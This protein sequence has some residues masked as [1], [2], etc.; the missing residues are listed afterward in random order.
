MS[1]QRPLR[2]PV[3]ASAIVSLPLRFGQLADERPRAPLVVYGEWRLS[4]RDV[5]AAANRLAHRL[6]ALGVGR[7]VAVGLCLDRGPDLLVAILAV[8]KAGGAYVPLD[9]HWPADRLRR[10]RAAAGPAVFVTRTAFLALVTADDR[11]DRATVVDL[12]RDQAAIAAGSSANPDVAIDPDQWCYLLFTSGST[13]TPKGVPVTHRNLAGLFPP[14]T[15]ALGFGPDD[16]WTWFHSASF[17]FSVWEIW[18]ALLHG[19]CLVIVPEHIRQDP[20]ALGELIADEQV[21]VFSQT[22]SAYRRVLHDERFHSCVAGSRLRY[23]ALSGEAVRRDD[24]AGWLARGHRARLINTYAITETAG[25]LTLRIYGAD[26]ATEAGARNLGL[27]LPGR[28]VLVLDAAGDPVPDGAAGELWVGGDCVTPGYLSA[29]E[30]AA[31]FSELA[32]PGAGVLRGYRTGDRVC[33]IADGSLEYLGRVDDQLKFRGH[34]IEPGDIETALRAHPGVRD[35]AVALR[36]DGTGNQ[37]LTAYIVGGG[38]NTG[39]VT[40]EARKAEAYKAD[41]WPSIGAYGIY[42]QWL[43]GLMNAEPVRLAAYRAAFVAAVPGKVVLDIGTGEDAVLARLCVDA[44]AAHVYAVEVLE[45]AAQR[46]R[47]L[48]R[49]LGLEERITVL[50]GDI[51]DVALPRPVDVCTQGI[52]GNIGGADGIAATWN[53]ARRHFAP[54]CVPVPEVCVTRIAALELPAGVRPGSDPGPCF[55]P[56]AADYARR[57]FASVGEPFDLRLCLRNVGDGDLL[58]DPA[59][60]EVLDFHGE[61]A[62]MHAGSAELTIAR[63]GLFDGCLLWTV[64]TAGAGGVVDYFREQKAWLPVFLPLADEPVPVRKGDRLYLQW[65]SRLESDPQFPDYFLEARLDGAGGSVDLRHVTRHRAGFAGG[66]RLHRQLLAQLEQPAPVDAEQVSVTELRHWLDARVPE[67][68]VPQSWVFLPELP[69][70]PGGKLDREAL[71]APGSARPRLAGPPVA[72]RTGPERELARLWTEVLGIDAPGVEDD[73]FELGGD[74]ISAVQLTTRIQRWLDAGVPLAALFE[75]PTIAGLA[76][77]LEERFADAVA[78]ALARPATGQS[79]TQP[80]MQLP[81]ASGARRVPLTFSQQSLWFLQSLYPGD[82]SASEQFAIRLRG[83]LDRVA[84]ERAWDQLIH[85]HPILSARFEPE[86]EI[87]VR[88]VIPDLVREGVT[89]ITSL[90]PIS[91]DLTGIAEAALR[92]PFDLA[93]GPLVRALLFRESA[94]SQVL[95]VTA[96]HIVAD[97]MSVPVLQADLA[98]LYA[99]EELPAAA[100]YADLAQQPA[101]QQGHDVAAGLE[102]WRHQLADP[103]PP[104]LQGLVRPPATARVSRRVAFTL[105]AGQADGLRRLARAANATPYMAMLAAF[106]TLLARL[107]GQADLCIGTPMTLR[108]TPELRDV[109]GCLVNP[110]VLRVP[111]EPARSFREQLDAERTGALA[112]FRHRAVPFSRVVQAVAP[113]R[114]LGVHP[115]FQILFSWEPAPTAVTAADGVEFEVISVPAARASYFN[116]E[117]ALRD[118]GEGAALSGYLAWSTT[119]LEDW[120]AE[121]LPGRLR[122]LLADVLARPDVPLE[123]LTL[124]APA[125]RRQIVQEWN[126]TAAPLPAEHGLH[127]VFLA[128]AA[129]SPDAVAIRAGSLAVSYGELASASAALAVE[130][131]RC[132]AQGRHVGIAIGRSPDLVLAVLAVLRAGGTVV[133]L[134]PGFP[135]SRLG[136]MA[137]DADLALLL[138]AGAPPDEARLPGLPVLDLATWPRPAAGSPPPAVSLP[139]VAGDA[140]AMM[141]Y[142]SGSTGQPKGARTTHRCAVNRCHW[143]WHAFGFSDGEVFALRTSLNF[144]DAWWEMFGA[145]GN[146]VP[147]QV[148]PDDVAT[149]P[150]RLPGFLAATGVTQLVLVPSLLRA[151]LEQLPATGR[152]LPALRWCITS[153][154]P[155]TPEL[156]AD[157]R[158]LLPGMTVLNTYGTSEIWDATAFDTRQL[159]AGAVRVPIGK[160]VANTRVYVVD[161]AGEVLPPGIPGELCVAGPGV[162]PGYWRR[163]ELTAEKF[164]T[165][166]LPELPAERVYRTGDRARFLP[167]GA[168]EC[169]GRLDAQFKLR[170]QRIEPAEIEQALARHPAVAA[171]VA[172]LVGD[173]GSTLLAA[174]VVRAPG[175]MPPGETPLA[176]VLRAHLEDCLPAW[177][178]PTAWCELAALPLTPTGKLDRLGGLAAASASPPVCHG[179]ADALLPR[180]DTQRELASLWCALLGRPAVGVEDNFFHLGGHSLLAARLLARIRSAFG[181]QLELRAL[182]AAPTVVALAAAIDARRQGAPPDGP[183]MLP[184]PPNASGS[185]PALSF[186]Q[187]R[188]WFLEQLDP[189]SPAYNVAWTIHCSGLLRLPALRAALDALV[190]RHPSLRTRFPAVAGRPVPIIDPPGPAPLEFRDLG[191]MDDPGAEL[192]RQLTS[193]AREPF[194]LGRGP[195][196]RATLLKTGERDHYLLL[197]A[198]HIVTDATSNHL[199]FAELAA[200]LSGEPEASPHPALPLT[201]SGFARRQRAEAGSPRQKSALDWWRERLAGAPAALEL[202]TDR[203]R[204]AEQRFA[205]AWVQR[206]VPLPLSAAL[207][208][209]AREQ[210]CTPYMVLLAAFKALLHRYSGAVDVLVGTPVEG[211]LTADVEPVVGLFINTLVMRTDLA[212]DPAFSTLLARVRETTLDAQAHQEVPFEQLVEA[213]APE[214]SLSRSPVFQVMFNLVRLPERRRRTGDLELRVDRLIDQ[215]VSSFDLTLTAAAD[216]QTLALTFEYATDLFDPET[217]SQL[218]DAYLC[219]LE[220]ALRDPEQR[221]S[222]LPLLDLRARQ[223]LLALGRNATAASRGEPVHRTVS[224]R[225]LCSPDAVAVQLGGDTLTYAGLEGRASRLSRHLLG[226]GLGHRARIGICLPRTPDYLVAVLAVLKSGAAYVPLDPTYPPE[227]LAAMATDAS[228]SGVVVNAVTRDLLAVAAVCVDLDADGAAIACQPAADPATAVEPEDTA[229]VLYTSGST[230][231]P[232]GVVVTHA[233]LAGA[234]AAWRSAYDL[235]PGESHLQMASAAF[236]VFTGDWVRSLGTG[237]RLVLCPRDVLLDPPAL[238]ALLRTGRIRVAEFVPAI[239][240]LLIG[241]CR[242][243][244]GQLPELRL[245]IVGSDTWHDSE[246][247]ALRRVTAPGTRLINSYGVAE[248]TVDSTWFEAGTAEVAG[249]IPIGTPFPGMSVYVLDAHGEPVPRGVPGELCIGGTGVAAGYWNDPEL[250]ARK[251]N[252]DPHAGVAGARLYRTGDRAR[253]NRS[254]QLELLGRSDAQFKLRGFRIEPA[255]IE[256]AI[257]TLPG[258]AAAA[259]N[260]WTPA[261][262][263]PRLVAWVV[264]Q[265][266]AVSLDDWRQALRRVLPE[267]MVPADFFILPSLPLT[268]NGKVDRVALAAGAPSGATPFPL[269]T[270]GLDSRG[271]G[272]APEGA[273]ATA[274]EATISR[275]FRDVLAGGAIAVDT[276]F[277]RAGGHSLLATRLLARLREELRAEIPLRLLFE[278]PT[279]RGLAAALERRQ[280]LRQSSSPPALPG[281]RPRVPGEAVPLSPM[282]QRLWFLERLQPGTAAYHL[283]WMLRLRGPLHREALQAAVDAVV[284]R[285]EVLRTVFVE[286]SGVPGQVIVAVLRI[287]VQVLASGDPA[288]LAAHLVTEPFD[289][290]AGPL[291]RVTLLEDGPQDHRLLVVIHHLVADGWSFAILARDLAA[292]YNAA[293]RGSAAGPPELPLQYADYALWQQDVLG[294]GRLGRQLAHW[295]EAL[296]GAPPLLELPGANPRV[297]SGPV[298]GPAGGRGEWAERT[299][300]ATTV[301]ALRELAVAEGCTLFMV[302]LAAFKALLG[303][304]AGRTD[305]VVGTPVAGRS[306]RALEDLVGFFVNTLVL[307]TRLEGGQTFRELLGRVRDTTLRA[308]EHADVPFEKLVEELKPVRSLAHSPLVQVLFA[309]H[310]QPRQPL[311]L[312]GLQASVETIATDTVKF[313]LNLHAAEEGGELHLALAWRNGL[314]GAEA[315]HGLLDDFTDLLRDAVA[316][317]DRPLAALLQEIPEPRRVPQSTLPATAGP[318]SGGGVELTA[319]GAALRDLWAALLG[320]RDLGPDDDFFAVGGHSL[321]AMRLVAAVADRLG[322]ELPLISIFEAPTIHQLARRVDEKRAAMV[323]VAAAI[324]RLPRRPDR[325][326]AG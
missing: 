119:A 185:A 133:P 70:G 273:P 23:L 66:T 266:E 274:L 300:P 55:G 61:L 75:A 127:E 152:S 202:P 295:R 109:V 166:A 42:D 176:A 8:L 17:G 111:V 252:P 50:Q 318:P 178:V 319:T 192:D 147:L 121:Q 260:L 193:L 326:D 34:R 68:L 173:E 240:R 303:R 41:F 79:A 77:H 25:Q 138:V 314:Y 102:W 37:R 162:G 40:A 163:P 247:A 244:G 199:L 298:D 46:A 56:L 30:L 168:V 269:E 212:G 154:E 65:Q 181:V 129:R 161:R 7:N 204:P 108:D 297:V 9:P 301:S 100:A 237:G 159:T 180:T 136:F 113:E 146:G 287:P 306:H 187:E 6:I 235:Q 131:V 53:A 188:L 169:L 286:R 92:E 213:L 182:F 11:G 31:R 142:T 174:G 89:G 63:D 272:V 86:G 107:T 95:I 278:A 175:W 251:F 130:L 19:G 211:R 239:I 324:P 27:P 281:P 265:D 32:V 280:E 226:L 284:A 150:L 305:V 67:H 177:M 229:Y 296:A 148:V 225:A 114:Q 304:L 316:T 52:I 87:G 116:L 311:E 323:T 294:D 156:V 69:L 14:L 112:A 310:N 47:D 58:S 83:R 194:D 74:S 115:L 227:R 96:H 184:A 291:V 57:V 12:D 88:L 246:L 39:P 250:T 165:L 242:A 255:E 20:A 73:F 219:L 249:P 10:M 16:V 2:A 256:S 206:A 196:F 90:T 140:A 190:A 277:F 223:R 315:M 60:F 234:L 253:W 72:P 62:A 172:G 320:R 125:E 299:I 118:A 321:L 98:R 153:G 268:P 18:G 218:A 220:G 179:T 44:G 293:R 84:L 197:V 104:A 248:A 120:V 267:H 207:E 33:R 143:M 232:K 105:D 198:Q 26:D 275:L 49:S 141:L 43:Y 285:H 151:I 307:R 257:A 264:T 24:I 243:S 228:L 48:V 144:I 210:G 309:L 201:Y 149:D 290:E 157:C 230:G 124:L 282:Q 126:A 22:P 78:A 283:H 103:P 254:G 205:G 208:R 139:G 91:H 123:R 164:G 241:H 128:H 302:L 262:G 132:G 51:A 4:Y 137:R 233:N 117:C 276:D 3:T 289:L 94:D 224:T 15:A 245:L 195:L 215:G 21:T 261:A 270:R 36:P 183:D 80:A 54:G 85:R 64:V 222:S 259:V 322:V 238:L 59:D 167:D 325:G 312:D 29:P 1:D 106:R 308:F 279:P 186:G 263:E 209:R 191:A 214:R 35:A 5:N 221:L 171:A 101:W 216:G 200:I 38:G 99:G 97:G 160:P 155:L 217:I 81:A 82:T 258:V 110:V 158:R 45:G 203:P 134:D 145:L 93:K 317:P 231:R 71:P 288:S 271:K 189:G 313:D 292:A 122:A 170:G 236:D 13:G 76:R 135:S 28:E